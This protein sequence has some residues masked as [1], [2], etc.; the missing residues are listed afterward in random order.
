MRAVQQNNLSSSRPEGFK[1]REKF[2]SSVRASTAVKSTARARQIEI[3]KRLKEQRLERLRNGKLNKISENTTA[4]SENNNNNY[5]P[6]LPPSLQNVDKNGLQTQNNLNLSK[7]SLISN[8][9]SNQREQK[10]AEK[11]KCFDLKLFKN[12]FSRVLLWLTNIRYKVKDHF[13]IHELE[14]N[15]VHIRLYGSER[16]I[17]DQNEEIRSYQDRGD[18]VLHPTSIERLVLDIG[19]LILVLISVYS[20]RI[21]SDS[22][23]D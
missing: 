10:T 6:N 19:T 14:I 7:S 12:F 9:Q 8:I 3:G 22:F 2:R 13:T 17:L 1:K 11:V 16:A 4:D 5:D 18:F 15:D 21:N 23:F 20:A